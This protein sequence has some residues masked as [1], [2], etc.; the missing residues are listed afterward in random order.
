MR[1]K[2]HLSF[3]VMIDR[4]RS[5]TTIE[6]RNFNRVLC[7]FLSGKTLATGVKFSLG[8]P[9]APVGA[10]Q[11]T[12]SAVRAPGS[13]ALA[14]APFAPP[15]AP[16]VFTTFLLGSKSFGYS[17]LPSVDA[18]E[19]GPCKPPLVYGH[20][21]DNGTINATNGASFGGSLSIP[22]TTVID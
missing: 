19:T 1:H 11:Q 12:F 10:T 8:S 5:W 3:L 14:S 2:Y 6:E 22:T 13:V 7:C 21:S 15:A 18:P 16:Q 9:W 4:R 17:L 20:G